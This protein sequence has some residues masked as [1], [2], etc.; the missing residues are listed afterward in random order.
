MAFFLTR[1]NVNDE[2]LAEKNER[3]FSSVNHGRN[4]DA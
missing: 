2:A 4:R 3:P 1:D